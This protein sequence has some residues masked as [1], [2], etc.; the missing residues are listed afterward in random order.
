MNFV[1][2]YTTWCPTLLRPSASVARAKKV[3]A[4]HLIRFAPIMDG[5]RLVGVVSATDLLLADDEALLESVMSRAPVT[6]GPRDTI[7]EAA[8][9]MQHTGVRHLVVTGP[10]TEEVGVLSVSDFARAVAD[11]RVTSPISDLMSTDLLTVG[12]EDLVSDVRPLLA[13]GGQTALLVTIDD[14]HCIGVVSQLGVLETLPPDV[15]VRKVMIDPEVRARPSTPLA[16]VASHMALSDCHLALVVDGD[17]N[18][19]GVV[20]PTDLAH[21]LS[22]KK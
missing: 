8:R 9:T 18:P 5:G 4:D 13:G 16:M 3:M 19:V 12:P 6:I 11:T 14:G 21:W 22:G 7:A 17:N 15:R 10:E 20:T 2:E 1:S